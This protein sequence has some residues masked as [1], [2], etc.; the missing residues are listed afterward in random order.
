MDAYCPH[1]G[2]HLGGGKVVDGCIQC[3]FHEWEF[4]SEGK[5]CK[6]PYFTGSKI[7]DFAKTNV[8]PTKTVFDFVFVW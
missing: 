3:P 6:I 1:Q 7:P 8:W 5:A 2:A 4:N